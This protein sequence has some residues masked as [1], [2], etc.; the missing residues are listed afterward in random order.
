[1]PLG[2]G[3]G[4]VAPGLPQADMADCESV[5]LVEQDTRPVRVESKP[6]Q[7][8]SVGCVTE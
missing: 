4:C 2:W 1:V 8:V 6:A 7:C 5:C 3:K